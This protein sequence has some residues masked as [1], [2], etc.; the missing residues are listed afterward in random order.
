MKKK[1]L[2]VL[3]LFILFSC[4]ACGQT[5]PTGIT[6]LT[7]GYS[8][9]GHEVTYLNSLI[10]VI[11]T[12]TAGRIRRIRVQDIGGNGSIGLEFYRAAAL[13]P[14]SAV[15]E[16]PPGDYTEASGA[17]TLPRDSVSIIGNGT[18]IKWQGNSE[19]LYLNGRKNI[20]ISG[21]SFIGT[22]D[23]EKTFQ[24]AIRMVR[25]KNINI[26]NC[27]FATL[28]KAG[29]QADDSTSFV[30]IQGNHFENIYANGYQP[31]SFNFRQGVGVFFFKGVRNSVVDG[32]TFKGDMG[33]GIAIDDAS[34]A[35]DTLTSNS[36]RYNIISNNNFYGIQGYTPAGRIGIAV[37]IE[38]SNNNLISGNTIDSCYNG[39]VFNNGQSTIRSKYNILSGN[40]IYRS[41][42]GA[43][44]GNAS[45]TAISGNAFYFNTYGV[46]VTYQPWVTDS[47]RADTTIISGNLFVGNGYSI[48][49]NYGNHTVVAFNT[50]RGST[51]SDVQSNGGGT[52]QY[53]NLKG[54][55]N[56]WSEEQITGRKVI[57]L[58]PNSTSEIVPNGS[59]VLWLQDTTAGSRYSPDF[60]MVDYYGQRILIRKQGS[61]ILYLNHQGVGFANIADSTGTTYFTG[62]KFAINTTVADSVGTINGSL[63]VIGRIRSEG[64]I[65]IDS[66]TGTI[67]RRSGRIIDRGA[68]GLWFDRGTGSLARLDTV[69]GAG[70]GGDSIWQQVG[71]WIQAVDINHRLVIGASSGD[72]LVAV[73]GGVSATNLRVND[74]LDITTFG[75]AGKTRIQG[76]DPDGRLDFIY[77]AEGGS[78]ATIFS[79]R[80]DA[81]YT[82]ALAALS[83]AI[84]ITGHVNPSAISAYTLGSAAASWRALHADTAYIGAQANVQKLIIGASG[85]IEI[86]NTSMPVVENLNSAKLNGATASATPTAT[87]IPI[88]GASGMVNVG[89][90]PIFGGQ[91]TLGVGDSVAFIPQ[92]YFDANLDTSY[93]CTANWE[94]S[95]A[96]FDNLETSISV[97]GV[98]TIKS[99]TAQPAGRKANYTISKKTY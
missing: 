22:A 77:D 74:H 59:K 40:E 75:G 58:G 86:N 1:S 90:I 84:A 48:S 4:L 82:S 47:L 98:V 15:I 31:G 66:A 11:V 27:R 62:D 52:K 42:Y 97:A 89:Y 9:R 34:S 81:T 72:S 5:L 53:L 12:D 32:N 28:T 23:S 37:L 43:V 24:V 78:Q 44:V 73:L 17:I 61:S 3:A 16:L 2:L 60:A 45:Q 51:I 20:S 94:S 85:D 57:L 10:G 13:A 93:V 87:T 33:R 39:V 49:D 71:G 68:A 19:W 69:Y 80:G 96:G 54:T 56:Q 88:S 83:T 8:L 99:Q 63:H 6:P 36:S 38:G 30:T 35:G 91:V 55:S 79:I 21:L 50:I 70:G 29:I 41:S 14:S 76:T 25:S 65:D 64:Y 95:A 18:T 67:G 7:R 92:T 46:R 26:S